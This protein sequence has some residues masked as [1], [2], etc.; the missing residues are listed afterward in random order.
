M[1]Q[2]MMADFFCLAIDN[3]DGQQIE[4]KRPRK[5]KIK[6]QSVYIMMCSVLGNLSETLISTRGMGTFT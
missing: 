2:W 3:Q 1:G 5:S 4:G 6:D